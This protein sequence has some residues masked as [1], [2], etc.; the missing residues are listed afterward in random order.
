[1]QSKKRKRKQY[2]LDAT[3]RE[4]DRTSVSQTESITHNNK[5][6]QP[7]VLMSAIIQNIY[8]MRTI[9]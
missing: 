7:S 8:V 1:M 5:A 4:S 3:K 9:E 6:T 2:K